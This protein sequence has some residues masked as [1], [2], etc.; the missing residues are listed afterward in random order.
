MTDIDHVQHNM[1]AKK[2]KLNIKKRGTAR[3]LR[4]QSKQQ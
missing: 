2:L 3:F 1:L 4:D